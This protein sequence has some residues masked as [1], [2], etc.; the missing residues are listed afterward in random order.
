MGT[1][2]MNIVNWGGIADGFV[3]FL[4][5]FLNYLVYGSYFSAVWLFSS[6][7]IEHGTNLSKDNKNRLQ[8][9]IFVICIACIML[10][11]ILYHSRIFRLI[12]LSY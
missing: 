6:V 8:V 4:L 11:C 9:G 5:G 3:A 2:L 12:P 10:L 1:D 7:I